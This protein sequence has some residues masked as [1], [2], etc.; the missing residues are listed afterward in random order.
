MTIAGYDFDPTAANDSVSFN[1]GVTGSVTAATATALTVSLTGLASLPDGTLLDAS[2]TVDGTSTA[3]WYRWEP[4]RTRNLL[5]PTPT[6][7]PAPATPAT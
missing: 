7:P 5:L 4:Y 2:A 6:V 3:T 1:N